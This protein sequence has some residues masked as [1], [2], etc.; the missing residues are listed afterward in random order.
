MQHDRDAGLGTGLIVAS[1]VAYSL[2]GYFTRLIELDVW[3]V[4][5]WR[6]IFAGVF[7]GAVA[8]WMHRRDLAG[9]VRAMG[10]P[11]LW[12]TI[13]SAVASI[14]YISALRLIPVAEVMTVHA[15]LPFVAA[16][17]ALAVTG[18]RENRATLAACCVALAG[19]A[20]IFD[21]R[22]SAD[23]MAGYGFAIL[24]VLSYGTLMVVIRRHRDVSMLPAACLS[25]FL[26]AVLVL[27]L[28]SPGKVPAAEML[29][30]ALFGTAQ[31][32]LGLLLMTVGTRLI[33]ATRSALIGSLENPLAPLWVWLAF[34]EAPSL[35]TWIGGGIVMAAV[36]GDVLVKSVR[37]RR[38]VPAAPS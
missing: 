27:P 37:T 16:L 33:S 4:L 31:F 10:W 20:I 5:F 6:G 38:A 26:C 34:A 23:H 18:E 25:A 35:S 30:L 36:A 11:S 21:P 14:S 12:V 19:V 24:M 7:I 32:G 9:M 15:A 3:T 17:L 1:A 28:A 13:L 22:A 2:A 8:A 29:E